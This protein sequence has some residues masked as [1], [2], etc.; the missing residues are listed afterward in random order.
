M[1]KKARRESMDSHAPEYLALAVRERACELFSLV[2]ADAP[3]LKLSAKRKW[4][5]IIKHYKKYRND[6][7]LELLILLA[8]AYRHTSCQL[9]TKPPASKK[10]VCVGSVFPEDEWGK[11]EELS[12]HEACNKILHTDEFSF[13]KKKIRN[14]ELECI[15]DFVFL[16]GTKDKKVWMALVWIP[17]FCNQFLDSSIVKLPKK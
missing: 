7:I 14:A 4:R 9:T 5:G 10:I 12:M 6:R 8:T 1:T 16:S 11:K 13:S 15:E 17:I 2:M 3:A